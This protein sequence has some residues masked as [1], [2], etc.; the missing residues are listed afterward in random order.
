MYEGK[1]LFTQI[2][3][4]MPWKTFHRIVVRYDAD[5]GIRTLPT[6]DQFRIM[7]FGQLAGLDSLRG[8]VA[9][10]GAQ[11]SKRYHMG[12]REEV[13]LS[14]LADANNRRDWRIFAEFAHKLIPQ[15]R[16]LYAD[17]DIGI[18]LPNTMYALDSTTIDL[19]LALFP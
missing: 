1:F 7:A 12:I 2:L 11:S 5:H 15:A 4:H 19:C 8:I 10:L 6:A 13:K 14:T 17:E 3:D 9:C 16:D 18:D